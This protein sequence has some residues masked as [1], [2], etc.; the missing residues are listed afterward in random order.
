MPVAVMAP[1]ADIGLSQFT[2]TLGGLHQQ[3]AVA[4]FALEDVEGAESLWGAVAVAN[5]I[6]LFDI[7][8]WG[9]RSAEERFQILCD[10][11]LAD[12]DTATERLREALEAK[13]PQAVNSFRKRMQNAIKRY[14]YRAFEQGALQTNPRWA[15]FTEENIGLVQEVIQEEYEYLRGFISR[16]RARLDEEA[17]MGDRLEWNA[18]LYANSLRKSFHAGVV[19]QGTEEDTVTVMRGNPRDTSCDACP[20]RWG[21]YTMREYLALQPPPPPSNWCEGRSNCHCIVEVQ[22]GKGLIPMPPLP[23]PTPRRMPK[24]STL[25]MPTLGEFLSLGFKS[26]RQD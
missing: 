14:A 3:M 21:I 20:P 19:S 1:P 2:A 7:P 26:G 5:A 15:G 17:P 8:A 12:I 16:V 9:G 10:L 23:G 22:K 18:R 25:A 11:F 6:C 4:Q 24:L 13:N